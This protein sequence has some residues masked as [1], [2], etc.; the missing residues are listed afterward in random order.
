M[1][2]V[3]RFFRVF[4]EGAIFKWIVVCLFVLQG[5]LL[6]SVNLRTSYLLVRRLGDVTVLFG[7]AIVVPGAGPP[8]GDALGARHPRPAWRRRGHR[9]K[10]ERY[11]PLR[12]CAKLLRVDGE[13]ALFFLLVL[14]PAGCLVTWLSSA[15]LTSYLPFSPAYVAAGTFLARAGRPPGRPALGRR[16]RL[17]GLSPGGDPRPAADHRG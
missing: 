6:L 3:R 12:L 9:Q 16:A 4:D 14:A 7:L 5:L 8:A 15:E 11:S 2:A 17:R 1:D 10:S 13:A